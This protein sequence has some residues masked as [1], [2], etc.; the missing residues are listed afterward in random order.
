[1]YWVNL[2][3]IYQ[4]P[5]Q[6]KQI[7]HKVVN[8]SYDK[9]LC[10]LEARSDV[11]INLNICA[12]LTEQLVE[13]GHSDILYR[14]KKLAEQGQIEL[15][16]SA[17]YHPILPLLPKSE[18]VRQIKLNENL[19]QKYFG[20]IW[21]PR[22]KGFFMPELACHKKTARIIQSLGYEWIVL[23]EIAYNGKFGK[24]S[25]DQRYE[26]K[27]LFPNQKKKDLKVVFRNRGM[28][29]IFFGK[30]LDSVDKFFSAIKNDTR[31]NKFLITAFD[32]EG[33]GH[34]R[35][36]LVDVWSRILD[37]KQVKTITYSEYLDILKSAP[38]NKVDPLASSWST[39]VE[40]MGQNIPYSLWDH[41]KNEIHKLQWKLTK[42]IIKLVKTQEGNVHYKRTRRM[43]DRALASDQY[44]WASVKPWWNPEVIKIG[45]S[46]FSQILSV[47]ENTL[48]KNKLQKANTII[49]KIHKEVEKKQKS[50][51]Y[52]VIEKI[53]DW[54]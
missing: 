25:F 17:K 8:E 32:G 44:W 3:H 7:I 35:K 38:L 26:I 41:P 36:D 24:V 31:S 49:D 2:L 4:P 22:P 45:T 13:Y 14:I 40:D 33:L 51:R 1:M 28:S 52:K 47:L 37:Q 42:L 43:L 18:V 21:R 5:F 12:S 11:E 48:S 9:I 23:D 15:V 10:I 29:L 19:N 16:G 53:S 39:E 46:Q 54:P 50:G 27:N 30:W 20:K 6:K 34:H